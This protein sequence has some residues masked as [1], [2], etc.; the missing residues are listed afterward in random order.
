MKTAAELVKLA[1]SHR[2]EKYI[3][4]AFAPKNNPNWRGPWDCAEFVS[5]VAFQS[6]SLLLG[7]TDNNADPSKAN[8]YSGAWA[9]DAQASHR[10]ISIGQARATAGAVLI[11]KPASGSP[12]HVAISRGDGTTIEA[13]S[14]KTGVSNQSVDGRRWDLAML[15]PLIEYPAELPAAVYA[16]P[17][18]LVL[19]LSFPPMHGALVKQAQKALKSTGIDPGEI[20]GVYGPHTAAAVRAFQLQSGLVPDGE[21][22][23]T[24]MRELTS[25]S[26]KARRSTK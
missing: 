7:C 18:E 15:I 5:W 3:L 10:R 20:D 21:V 12:G 17:S 13:H 1:N 23:S 8:A 14:A 9:R 2:G 6:T 22:G 24:T 25:G 16:P 11:R 19:R 26:A 4:G